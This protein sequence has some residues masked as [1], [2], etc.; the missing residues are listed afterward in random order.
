MYNSKKNRSL[1][2]ISHSFSYDCQRYFNLCVAE[3]NIIIFISGNILHFWNISTNKL[4]FRRGYTGN[5]IGHITV[6]FT[7]IYYTFIYFIFIYYLL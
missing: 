7:F 4:W 6:F 5:G 1:D 2:N 3:P